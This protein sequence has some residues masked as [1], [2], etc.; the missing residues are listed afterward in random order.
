[1]FFFYRLPGQNDILP[2]TQD[3]FHYLALPGIAILLLVIIIFALI[4][5]QVVHHAAGDSTIRLLAIFAGILL[6]SCTLVGYLF[7]VIPG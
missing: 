4:A 7:N 5:G 1:M 3:I 2:A 6:V